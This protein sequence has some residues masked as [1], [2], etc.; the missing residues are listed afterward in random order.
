[1]YLAASSCRWLC[2]DGGVDKEVLSLWGVLRDDGLWR[3]L[4]LR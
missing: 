4:C 1:M 3:V 2:L